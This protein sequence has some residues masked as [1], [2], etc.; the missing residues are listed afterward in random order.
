MPWS[1][2]PLPFLSLRLQVQQMDCHRHHLAIAKPVPIERISRQDLIGTV[3][4]A[5]LMWGLPGP[6]PAELRDECRRGRGGPWIGTW[7]PLSSG[8]VPMLSTPIMSSWAA[9]CWPGIVSRKWAASQLL[10]FKKVIGHTQL[11]CSRRLEYLPTNHGEG[12]T[13]WP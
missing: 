12:R 6:L 7:R 10:G 2:H 1:L 11:S 3:T 9:S 8:A 13:Y 4:S 5:S